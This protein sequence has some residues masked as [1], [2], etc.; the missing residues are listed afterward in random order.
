MCD[1]RRFGKR[2]YA[3]GLSEER[4]DH[5]FALI[6]FLTVGWGEE[7]NSTVERNTWLSSN[8]DWNS[9][10][11][12]PQTIPI[13]IKDIG[14]VQTTIGD[15]RPNLRGAYLKIHTKQAMP[16]ACHGDDFF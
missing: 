1:L 14:E 2:H 8:I 10:L 5:T 6:M 15:L 16:S 11:I 7:Q 12:R 4:D 13:L 3:P 9:L